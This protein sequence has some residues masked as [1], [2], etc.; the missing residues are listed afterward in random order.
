MLGGD[1]TVVATKPGAGT[2]F[3]LSVTVGSLAN[4]KTVPVAG[5]P[6]PPI[7]DKLPIATDVWTN[8]LAGVRLL[9]AEDGLDNQ[10]L[11]AFVLQRSGAEVLTVENGQLAV[12]QAMAAWEAGRPFD[13]I[14]MDMQMPVMDGYQ[15]VALLR[16]KDYR[17]P[18]VALTAHAMTGDRERCLAMGCDDY[19]SKPIDRNCLIEQI[20]RCAKRSLEAALA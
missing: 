19:V 13:A 10:R 11:I 3:R 17:G 4:V 9:L 16:A 6:L 1:V 15:A 8:R 14:L 12:E 18:I 20:A 2:T 5:K 7:K